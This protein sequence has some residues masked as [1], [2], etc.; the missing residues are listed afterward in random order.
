MSGWHLSGKIAAGDACGA[1]LVQPGAVHPVRGDW[2]RVVNAAPAE[3]PK[4]DEVGPAFLLDALN[5]R[6]TRASGLVCAASL[7]EARCCRALCR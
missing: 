4:P 1:W 7:A 3:G 5:A 6:S 2:Q